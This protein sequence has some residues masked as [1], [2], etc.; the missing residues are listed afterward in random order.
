MANLSGPTLWGDVRSLEPANVRP[1]LRNVTTLAE[2]IERER[3]MTAAILA[4]PFK[5]LPAA[6]MPPSWA[7]IVSSTARN[8]RGYYRRTD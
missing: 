5:Y 4:D 6:I 1:D 8:L 2:A 7:K 3:R